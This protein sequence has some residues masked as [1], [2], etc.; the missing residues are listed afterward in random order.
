M[1]HAIRME[2]HLPSQ[3]RHALD[4]K[5][6][7]EGGLMTDSEKGGKGRRS[8]PERAKEASER[9]AAGPVSGH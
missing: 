1:D 9:Q 5:T 4:P 2:G 7:T 8:Q 3:S 6:T